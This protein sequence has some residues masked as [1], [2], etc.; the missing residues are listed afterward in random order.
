MSTAD[1]Y[2]AYT[3]RFFRKSLPVH[4]LFADFRGHDAPELW[5]SALDQHP[6]E[7]A[8]ALAA[9]SLLSFVAELLRE[10]AR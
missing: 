8:H 6:N 3:H 5:V 2:I 4:D 7:K 9:E 1:A 10:A